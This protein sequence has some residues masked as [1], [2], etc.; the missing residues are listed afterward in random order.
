MPRPHLP[1]IL[2]P[3]LLLAQ[4]ACATPDLGQRAASTPYDRY[5]APVRRVLSN[6][7]GPGADFQRV[8]SLMRTGR[9]FRY[10]FNEPYVAAAPEVTARTRTGDCKAKSLWLAA[11]LG[12][13]HIR[14]VIGKASVDSGISHAWLLWDDGRRWWILDPTNQRRPL[15]ADSAPPDQYIALY[16]WSTKGVFRHAANL[17]RNAEDI[18]LRRPNPPAAAPASGREAGR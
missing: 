15:P 17:A 13:P 11:Q 6:L 5:M 7:H 9:G 18:A 10:A 12:D 1:A 4:I 14:Y 3:L 2:G 16:S 8:Q